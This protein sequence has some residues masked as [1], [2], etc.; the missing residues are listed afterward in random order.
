MHNISNASSIGGN[1]NGTL[2]GISF[3]NGVLNNSSANGKLNA[4]PLFG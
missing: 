4:S 2:A 3:G 1:G